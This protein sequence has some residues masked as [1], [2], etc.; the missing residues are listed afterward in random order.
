[1]SAHP[2]VA[3]TG[4]KHFGL[5]F[6]MQRV[7]KECARVERDLSA[8]AVHDLRVALRRCRSLASG[9]SEV[10]SD[11]AWRD[12]RRES[13]KLFRRL[14]ALRDLH[15]QVEWLQ[16]LAPE[17]DPLR[18]IL[19]E[20]MASR[21]SELRSETAAALEEFDGKQWQAWSRLLPERARRLPPDGLVA[22]HLALE[23]WEEARSMH[24]RALRNRN[25]AAWHELRI[26]IKRFRY[27][28]EN[29]LPARYAQWGKDLKRLQDLL[30]EVHD[31]DVL[32]DTLAEAGA[33]LDAG[34]QA[35][36]DVLIDRE[37]QARL[38]EYRRGMA[39]RGALWPMWRSELPHGPRL[40]AAAL[41]KLTTW[42]AYLDPD[43]GHSRHVGRLALCLFDGLS[44]AGRNGPFS[45]PRSRRL[46]HAAAL[47]HNAGRSEGKK[48]AHKAAYRMISRLE[49]P[50]GWT[51]EGMERVALIARYYRGA[52][53]E[54]NHKGFANL[55]PNEQKTITCLAAVLR[56]A[57]A[58]DC[59]HDS[60]VQGV[61][62]S[63]GGGFVLLEAAGWEE[64]QD[65]AAEIGGRKHLLEKA[66]G[67][68]VIVRA[69]VR[70]LAAAAAYAGPPALEI[71]A[72]TGTNR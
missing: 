23:R 26:G 72:R 52:E 34:A 54:E 56:L 3:V 25:P 12:M 11:R 51:T 37:R 43:V 45:N 44:A 5:R 48:G 2:Q 66:L 13:R 47:L 58:L 31:L 16:K 59:A 22:Q 19:L 24:R 62:V 64:N 8:D 65:N 40:E 60:S 28:V 14:G 30:G 27:T 35:R 42:A 49:P 33:A 6:W 1:M 46:L 69:A 68:P 41:A 36:W 10:D 17:D 32:R 21:E 70:P 50:M 20:L 9:L 29:F 18:Q 38:D 71:V 7:L 4:A 53:P 61:A 57:D 39:G 15:V 67:L 63:N 55:D